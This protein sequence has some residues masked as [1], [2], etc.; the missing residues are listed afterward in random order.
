MPTPGAPGV[1]LESLRELINVRLAQLVPEGAASGPAVAA[2][3]SL[4]APGK[5]LRAIITLSAARSLGGKIEDALDAACAIEMIHTSSL[6]FDDLPAMD[7]ADLRRGVPTAHAMF[8]QDIAIL[9]GIG[10]INGAYEVVANSRAMDAERRLEVLRVITRAVGWQG[11]VHGQALDLSS[12]ENTASLDAIHEGKTGVLFIA[13]A[14]CGGIAAPGSTDDDRRALRSYG[15]ALGF[16]YQAYDDV[17]D[18]VACEETA[19]KTT[20]KDSGKST[21]VLGR[22]ASIESATALANRH[23]DTAVKAVGEDTPLATLAEFIR[24]YFATTIAA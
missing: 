2:R 9:A 15:R 11:L 20:G 10:L 12:G 7:D 23:L 16:A 18:Q 1:D 19:G 4:L 13:A 22:R 3:H 5:R 6:V 21:A 17:L 8:G 14:E 24:S